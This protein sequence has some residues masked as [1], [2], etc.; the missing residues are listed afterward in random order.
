M[1]KITEQ[2]ARA[3]KSLA[4]A[5]AMLAAVWDNNWEGPE[6]FEGTLDRLGVLPDTCL[7]ETSSELEQLFQDSMLILNSLEVIQSTYFSPTQYERSD[8][9]SFYYRTTREGKGDMYHKVT[10]LY[11][12]Y[13]SRWEPE[14]E[15]EPD[16]KI[17][18]EIQNAQLISLFKSK[19]A[20]PLF[21]TKGRNSDCGHLELKTES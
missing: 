12:F 15:W 21:I 18:A 9:S 3:I 14:S 6:S 4:D 5:Y 11:G 16:E 1:D 13:F 17:T 2:Q 20:S 7:N 19:V 10:R 8:D